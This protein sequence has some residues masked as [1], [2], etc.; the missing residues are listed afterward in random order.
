MPYGLYRV[1]ARIKYSEQKIFG[2]FYDNYVDYVPCA[3]DYKEDGYEFHTIARIGL[4][5]FK[6][7]ID[8]VKGEIKRISPFLNSKIDVNSIDIYTKDAFVMLTLIPVKQ[9]F[10]DGNPLISAVSL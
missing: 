4:R 6:I 10:S 2:I 7:L 3:I 1:T 9:A 8:I 5:I